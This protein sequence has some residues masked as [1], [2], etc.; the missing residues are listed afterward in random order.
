MYILTGEGL[1]Q[2][3]I[4]LP[5]L[6]ETTKL[7]LDNLRKALEWWDN[8]LEKEKPSARIR[9]IVLLHVTDIITSLDRYIKEGCCESD[10]KNLE[11]EVRKLPWVWSKRKQYGGQILRIQVFTDIRGACHRLINIIQKV[12]K[13]APLT[14]CCNCW[15]AT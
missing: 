6:C 10:L 4:P 5:S 3:P 1:G 9:R 14:P 8:E 2:V 11:V 12:Q 13:T 15:T 7:H